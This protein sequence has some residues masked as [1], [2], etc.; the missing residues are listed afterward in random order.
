MSKSKVTDK[1]IAVA[2]QIKAVLHAPPFTCQ[3]VWP[4]VDPLGLGK[5]APFIIKNCPPYGEI[6]PLVPPQTI[7]EEEKCPHQETDA[8]S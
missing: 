3:K 7:Q 2:E 4:P 6:C 8:P 5:K 1:H